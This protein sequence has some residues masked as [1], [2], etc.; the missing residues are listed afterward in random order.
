MQVF[1]VT[2]I[3]IS[4]LP[5]SQ[6]FPTS[7]QKLHRFPASPL[8][9][10]EKKI[11]RAPKL[12]PYREST[13]LSKAV[14]VK[15]T[16]DRVHSPPLVFLLTLEPAANYILYASRSYIR[17]FSDTCMLP[18]RHF[19]CDRFLHPVS[20][21]TR[22]SHYIPPVMP[23]PS[24]ACTLLFRHFRDLACGRGKSRGGCIGQLYSLSL[25]MEDF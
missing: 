12:T 7:L 20:A 16:P 9:P 4:I 3:I 14:F 13:I 11:L 1:Q 21:H 22:F 25:L 6:N 8:E 5:S 2:S 24:L 10:T 18:S 19:P 17:A 15:N 23:Y